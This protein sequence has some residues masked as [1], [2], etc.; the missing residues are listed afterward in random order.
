[1]QL[2][3]ISLRGQFPHKALPDAGAAG[4]LDRADRL[5]G[6]DALRQQGAL[7]AAD[8]GGGCLRGG[9]AQGNPA[10]RPQLQHPCGLRP[11]HTA[12]SPVQ[13]GGALA[14]ASQVPG[15]VAPSVRR[16]SAAWHAD[17]AESQ[18]EGVKRW[19]R[20]LAD[21]QCAPECELT[22]SL[23]ICLVIESHTRC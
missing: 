14:A 15:G 22:P 11:Q 3:D 17:R 21:Q 20:R 19:L 1:M 10:G 23:L 9:P 13:L 6:P 8:H 4:K 12:R 18:R 5:C 16:Q 7:G 2:S